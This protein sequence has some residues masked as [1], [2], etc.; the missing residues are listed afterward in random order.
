MADGWKLNEGTVAY[1]IVTE[2]QLW[3][4]IVKSLSSSSKKTT[5]YKF[6]LLRAILENLYKTN[7][8]LELSFQQLGVSFAK[9]YWNLIIHNGYSQGHNTQIEKEINDFR[10]EYLIPNG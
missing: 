1:K 10:N 4:V 3:T 6:A 8:Q 5:S 9:L 2:D 7:L